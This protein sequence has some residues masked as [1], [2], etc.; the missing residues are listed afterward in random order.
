MAVKDAKGDLTAST[1]VIAETDLAFYSGDDALTLPLLS[2][3]G[4][5][6]VGTSTHFSGS[7]TESMIE[8]YLRGDVNEARRLHA[9]LLPIYTGI[10]R[11]QGTVLVKAGLN[12]R[13]QPVG[14]RPP[15][16]ASRATDHE[17]SHLR[18]DLARRRVCDRDTTCLTGNLRPEG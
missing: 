6:V 16:S 12:L 9:A 3:G 14:R 2:I 18:S 4:M 7:G 15:P 8:A 10:F 1:R 13:G 11:T 17:I 5:G